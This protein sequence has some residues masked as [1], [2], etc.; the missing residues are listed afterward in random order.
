MSTRAQVMEVYGSIDLEGIR[1][2]RQKTHFS[3]NREINGI[4][5]IVDFFECNCIPS[6]VG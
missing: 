4:C 5:T 2:F 1:L 6:I 3:L